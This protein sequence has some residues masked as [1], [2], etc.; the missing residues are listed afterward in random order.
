[1]MPPPEST[2]GIKP[3]VL[4]R[5]IDAETGGRSN[6][7]GYGEAQMMEA[8]RRD[9][10]NLLNTRRASFRQIGIDDLPEVQRSVA[11]YGLPDY[12]STDAATAKQREQIGQIIA[13]MIDVFEPRLYDVVVTVKDPET[14]K[15][16]KRDDFQNT[17]LYFHIQARLRMDPSP[18]VAFDTVL[19]LTKGRHQVDPGTS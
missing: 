3:S 7:Q 17:A 19:E 8:V 2:S 4:D 16:Q 13:E 11:G 5:L 9:L 15:Q 10:E 12:V 18:D 1:M 14:V 6:R